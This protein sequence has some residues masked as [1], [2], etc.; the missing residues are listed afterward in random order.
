MLLLAQHSVR[1]ELGVVAVRML[2][3]AVD[4]GEGG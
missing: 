1:V 3:A 2:V 4:M